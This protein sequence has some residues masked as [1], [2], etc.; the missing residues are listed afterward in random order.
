MTRRPDDRGAI[1][2][3]M[4]ILLVVVF[5]GA[6][7]VVDGGRAMAAR[8]HAS[9]TA[10]AAAR[11]AVSIATPVSGFDP[12]AARRAAVDHAVRAGVSA[13]DVGVVVGTDFVRVTVIERRRTVFLVLGGASTMTVQATG[14]AR[15]VYSDGKG[16]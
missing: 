9:N 4:M 14:V 13:A 1:T 2:V 8:R 10:E 11:A 16:P 3:V 15:V 6:G 5:A 12:V 7:L